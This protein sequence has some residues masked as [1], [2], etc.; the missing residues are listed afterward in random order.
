MAKQEK[1]KIVTKKHMARQ[2]R[3]ELQTR[4]IIYGS[5][6]LITVVLILVGIALVDTYIITPNK[7][8]A[9]VNGEDITTTDYQT[10]AKFERL[11]LV[12]QF[13]S[14]L[15]LMQS[16]DDESTMQYFLSSL[17]QINF[18][19]TPELHGQT[20]LD[21][22]IDDVLI[23]QES[24]Q[25]GI[26]VS[27][28]EIDEYIEGA[29]GYFPGG[30]PTPV[31]TR[32]PL[33]TSTL[34][35]EQL[36]LVPPIPTEESIEIEDSEGEI[37][38]DT[39]GEELPTPTVYTEDAFNQ[40]Y[41]DTLQTYRQSINISEEQFR[42]ILRA[43]ILRNKMLDEIGKN[44]PTEETQIW[45]RHI[46]VET[47]EE[48][49]VVITRLD[50]GEDFSV[51]AIDVSTDTGSGANGGDLGWFGPGRM[52]PEFENAAF[53]LKV[54]ETSLPIQSDFGF[55]IIQKLGQEL[56]P[57]DDSTL[58][59]LK[60]TTFNDWVT[61]LRESSDIQA[62]DTWVSFYPETPVIPPEY[63]ALLSQ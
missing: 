9:S 21:T 48:A 22:M 46:L 45:A 51:V 43:E 40:D 20:V 26:S 59:Q 35:S 12:N 32:E 56:R 2:E 25:L 41:E 27:E 8:V 16:F 57:I 28:T 7:A 63:L 55:H 52:V 5:I 4:Y 33:P 53:S 10:R 29:F 36:T 24:E 14:T 54:G 19:L 58:N 18:Q 1:Q 38:Q 17:Q 30:T 15:Q 61:A 34:S 44:T 39:P 62:D 13:G 47:E 37:T 6:A 42:D 3:E 23:R 60:Q 11:Q 31:P 49:Q 50:N